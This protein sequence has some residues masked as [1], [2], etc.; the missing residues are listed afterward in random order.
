VEGAQEIFIGN[1]QLT[2]LQNKE[3]GFYQWFDSIQRTNIS[4]R[5]L[6]NWENVQNNLT[7]YEKDLKVLNNLICDSQKELEK[8]VEII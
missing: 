4:L 2:E 1:Y 3:L 8:R 6:V 7:A 5:Q